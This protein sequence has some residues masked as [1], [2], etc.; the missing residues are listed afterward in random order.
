M[1]IFLHYCSRGEDKISVRSKVKKS[2][3]KIAGNY[4][5]ISLHCQTVHVVFYHALNLLVG[6]DLVDS[7][8]F[9]EHGAESHREAQCHCPLVTLTALQLRLQLH[10]MHM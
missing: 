7:P 10:D 1:F 4:L 9:T 6:K 2:I 5:K 3:A 8:R